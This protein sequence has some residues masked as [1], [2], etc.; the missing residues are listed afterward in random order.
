VARPAIPEPTMAT[1][2]VRFVSM[3]CRTA[4]AYRRGGYE[5]VENMTV[6]LRYIF[7]KRK[8]RTGRRPI[9]FEMTSEYCKNKQGY[10]DAER[11]PVNLD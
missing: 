3:V 8:V 6:V 7:D 10:G 5:Y 11:A 1:R 2:S 9:E 4:Q